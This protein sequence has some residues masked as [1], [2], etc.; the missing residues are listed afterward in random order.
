MGKPEVKSPL[1]RPTR[2]WED[3]IEMD[4]RE[5]GWGGMDWIDLIENRNQW[6]DFVNTVTN[7]QVQQNIEK[8]LSSRATGGFSVRAQ[9]RGVSKLV[10]K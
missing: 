3:N 6:R 9:L 10:S 4:F 7:L 8:S 2:W 5:I 1:G